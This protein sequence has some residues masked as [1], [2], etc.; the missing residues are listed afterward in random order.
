MSV[1]HQPKQL[2]KRVPSRCLVATC[3]QEIYEICT[4]C[5]VGYC[6]TCYSL[7]RRGVN[8]VLRK[9]RVQSPDSADNSMEVSV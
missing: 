8:Q 6:R 7:H 1:L 4:C 2:H 5:D 9:R 3:I